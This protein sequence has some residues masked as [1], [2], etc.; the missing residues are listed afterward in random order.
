MT[1]APEPDLNGFYAQQVEWSRCGDGFECTSVRVPI[2][3]ADPQGPTID[4]AVTRHLA[5]GDPL[6]SLV[7]NPGGPGGSGI[8][9][10]RLMDYVVSP[11]VA[12]A[13][14]IVGFDPRGVGDSA[15][16]R[17]VADDQIDALIDADGSPDTPEEVR[18]LEDLAADFAAGCAA[19]ELAA[20]M[21]TQANARDLD[22]LRAVL[23]H[24]RLDY[25]GVSYGTHLG[26]TYAAM[27]PERVGRFV[28]DAPLPADLDAVELTRGQALGFEDALT[29]F[30]ADCVGR[31]DCPFDGTPDEAMADLQAWLESLDANGIATADE[32]RPLTQGST[33]YAILLLLYSPSRD[34]PELRAGLA[35]AVAGDGTLLQLSMD[36]RL[37]RGGDGSYRDNSMQAFPAV[38]CLD[39]PVAATPDLA[40]QLAQEWSIDAPI[41]GE[42]L[43]WG[44]LSCEPWPFDVVGPAPAPAEDLPP[45]LVVAT[46]HD[47][48]TPFPWGEQLAEQLGPNA[49]LLVRDGDGHA[50]YREGVACVDEAI[51]GFLLD[52]VMPAAGTVC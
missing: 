45:I 50:A 17:C 14:D 49:V 18:A 51:D 32:A 52:G 7:L 6:G 47:P 39:R 30:M 44:I 15:G 40:A 8:E 22:I 31:A 26:A 27:F 28:L 20:H 1:A 16:I 9:Y 11:A 13:Y 38:S 36:A 29:R 10:A 4:L 2:D 21:S 48:A 42:F 24:E 3:Y 43:A 41:F 25:L 19:V 37:R 46:T 33:L 12:R 35:E 23:G 5:Q 34:W